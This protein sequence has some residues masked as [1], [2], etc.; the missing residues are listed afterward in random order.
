MELNSWIYFAIGLSFGIGL[1]GLVKL[2]QK[3]IV[4]SFVEKKVSGD[5]LKQISQ[6]LK[7]SENAYLMAHEMCQFKGG[8]LARTTHELRSPLNG[9]I[10]LHQLILQDLCENPQE[11]REFIAQA[12]ERTLLLLKLL[13]SILKVA[14]TEHGTNRLNISTYLVKN[15]L[16]EVDDLTRMLAQNR[17]FPFTVSIPDSEVYVLADIHWLRQILLGLVETTIAQME[18][19]GIHIGAEA[20]LIDNNM[21]NIFLDI[22]KYTLPDQESID[23]LQSDS[24]SLDEKLPYHHFQEVDKGADISHGMKLLLNQNLL[25]SMGGNLQIVPVADDSGS[26]T[27]TV[28]LQISMPRGVPS[29]ELLEMEE[30]Q[31]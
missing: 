5:Q 29:H 6:R 24:D 19:G 9:L 8:F 26:N 14:R 21:V 31:D 11:E 1:C 22:P 28:K 7:H 12:H 15:L 10:G 3:K 4:D 23:L 2:S 25:E 27:D 20:S 13:D 18:E 17:N 30:N 16:Q